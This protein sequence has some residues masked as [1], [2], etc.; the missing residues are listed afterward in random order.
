[1]H[2]RQ[3]AFLEIISIHFLPSF[4]NGF[5]SPEGLL[6]TNITVLE[7]G[8]TVIDC[9]STHLTCFA[10]LVDV[11]GILFSPEETPTQSFNSGDNSSSAESNDTV[12]HDRTELC[13][14]FSCLFLCY[15][16]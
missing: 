15:N 6:T 10:V 2:L 11:S 14:G 4:T 7:D 9:E 13:T 1:M 8:T 12:R 5:W 16:G 3:S